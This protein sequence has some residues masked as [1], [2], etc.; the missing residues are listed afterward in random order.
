MLVSVSD[1]GEPDGG[2]MSVRQTNLHAHGPDTFFV[3]APRGLW[4]VSGGPGE[5]IS[6]QQVVDGR[7]GSHTRHALT[8]ELGGRPLAVCAV[9]A[10]I[11]VAVGTRDGLAIAITDGVATL[12]VEG[13]VGRGATFDQPVSLLASPGGDALL[14]AYAG[15]VAR[16]DV[17]RERDARVAVPAYIDKA[18]P[19]LAPEALRR[20]GLSAAR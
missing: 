6:V 5:A 19:A 10:G 1:P 7:S 8:A 4:F 18:K 9:A 13:V 15:G 16:C 11:A 17:L 3:A 14:V 12:W 20:E 2:A